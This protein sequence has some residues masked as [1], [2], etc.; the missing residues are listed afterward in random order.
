MVGERLNEMEHVG[1]VR[2]RYGF[3]D[4]I[5]HDGDL[6]GLEHLVE[7][8]VVPGAV[9]S[10]RHSSPCS[11]R[12][13]GANGGGG[14]Q[15]FLPYLVL[16]LHQKVRIGGGVRQVRGRDMAVQ[17]RATGDPGYCWPTRQ[18]FGLASAGLLRRSGRW[19]SDGR[20]GSGPEAEPSQVCHGGLGADGGMDGQTDS[21]EGQP[22]R[23][24]DR[25]MYVCTYVGRHAR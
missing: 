21:L 20:S 22:T 23:W 17:A 6:Q 5:G 11:A 15:D 25:D 7:R 9:S 3:H 2:H 8:G 4:A 1:V 14:G 13:N 18:L 16:L 24:V 12:A 19:R 10:A